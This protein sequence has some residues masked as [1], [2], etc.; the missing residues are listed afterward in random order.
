[1]GDHTTVQD[2][3]NA[4]RGLFMKSV[5]TDFHVLEQMLKLGLI[6]SR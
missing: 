4:R 5:I 1:M 6:E 2:S 3:D